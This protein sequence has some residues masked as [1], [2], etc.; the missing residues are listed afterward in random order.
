MVTLSK[1]LRYAEG[2]SHERSSRRVPGRGNGKFKGPKEEVCLQSNEASVGSV[3]SKEVWVE[4][5]VRKY[6]V[7]T[8][9]PSPAV[10][11]LWFYIMCDG[12][13]LEGFKK[14]ND[15]G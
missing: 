4:D 9:K 1:D 8:I 3:V 12:N 5:E 7:Q 11:A 15:M 2:E 10:G 13:P 6:Q 14:R